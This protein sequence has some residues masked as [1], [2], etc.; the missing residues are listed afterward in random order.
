MEKANLKSHTDK[1]QKS[2]LFSLLRQYRGIVSVMIIMALA[3]SGINLLIPKIIAQAIDAFSANAFKPWPVVTE[4]L[5]A[6]GAI[7]FFTF[8]Q[9]LAQTYTSEKV[10]KDLRTRLADKISH[11]S[12][13]FIL[14]SN[15]SKLLTNLTSDTDSIK[16]FV[17]QAFV[18]IISSFFVI[19]GASALLISIN[20]KLAIAVISIVPVI[21]VTF[22]IVLR[23]V[24]VLFKRSREIIDSL[25][26]II[27]ESIM[28]SCPGAGTEFPGS[29]EHEIS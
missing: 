26:R 11:Q 1:K 18:T 2:G 29:G 3:G 4:F 21:A 9:S 6:A 27:N 23:K 17:S 16:M 15:P 22:F 24:R 28:G 5:I 25:N 8:L 20:W 14:K 10:A 12:F 19:I 13:M 7:F